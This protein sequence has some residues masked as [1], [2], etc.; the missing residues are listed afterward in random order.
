[1]K[2]TKGG[3][4]SANSFGNSSRR[5]GGANSISERTATTAFSAD[6]NKSP[7]LSNGPPPNEWVQYT[8]SLEDSL[9]EAKEYAAALLTKS[10]GYQSEIL[11]ELKEQRKQTQLAMEQNKKLMELLAK[12]MMNTNVN[13]GEDDKV[14]PYSRPLRT[15]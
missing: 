5:T 13:R 11:Q 12:N 14:K 3:Y 15:K 6:S 9:V 10:G 2:E 7:P 4:E 8:D 1:M